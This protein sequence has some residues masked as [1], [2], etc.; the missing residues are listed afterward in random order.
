MTDTRFKYLKYKKKY[1]DLKKKLNNKMSG[2]APG[3]ETRMKLRR[4]TKKRPGLLVTEELDEEK[5]LEKNTL[6]A[7]DAPRVSYKPTL[8]SSRRSKTVREAFP[9]ERLGL[10][11]STDRRRQRVRERA[12]EQGWK[13]R[14]KGQIDDTVAKNRNRVKDIKTAK[15]VDKRNKQGCNDH[16]EWD[17][18]EN[19]L[20]ACVWD[21]NNCSTGIKQGKDEN[22]LEFRLRNDS[23]LK[24][25]MK[26]DLQRAKVR[27]SRENGLQNG[28]SGVNNFRSNKQTRR[29]WLA[30]DITPELRDQTINEMLKDAWIKNKASDL[31]MNPRIRD[32]INQILTKVDGEIIITDQERAYEL[33]V[34]LFANR[35]LVP[36]VKVT[37]KEGDHPNG[38]QHY[39][40][41]SYRNDAAGTEYCNELGLDYD[42]ETGKCVKRS[43]RLGSSLPRPMA[44]TT[45]VVDNEEMFSDTSPEGEFLKKINQDSNIRITKKQFLGL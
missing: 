35:K 43:S 44:S 13:P 18:N 3:D 5:F 30:E 14:E 7:V 21:G 38:F 17:F 40:P 11:G 34:E 24:D 41:V 2:G 26:E 33:W 37:F 23:Y 39:R 45:P 29:T 15:C 22:P 6:A 8:R 36:P 10:Y 4:E 32:E 12:I 31:A 9:E 42:S 1:L 20:V 27:L 25:N 19:T 28:Q 16:S